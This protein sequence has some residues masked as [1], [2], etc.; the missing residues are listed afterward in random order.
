MSS[1]RELPIKH[2]V[3][4]IYDGPH[5][6]PAISSEGPIFLGIKNITD[7]GH[8]NFSEIRHV[9]ENEL[10]KW[11]RR[12]TPQAGDVVLTY[13]ATLHRYAIIPEGFRGC[14]GRRVALVRPDPVKVDS[15][16]LLFYF[17]SREWRS[18][19]E[20]FIIT[21]ATVNRI[22]LEKFPDFPVTLPALPEQQRIAAILS[23]YDDAME[24]NRRRMALLEKAAR[25]LYEEWFVR[26]RFPGHEH[27]PVKDGLPQGW[28]RVAFEEALVL[29]RGF[30]LPKELW[31]EGEFP[32]CG[33]TGIIGHHIAPKVKGPGVFT[34]RSGSLGIV[35]YIAEE[36]WPHNTALWVKEF[37]RVT[38]LFALFLMRG[39]NLKQYNGGASVPTLD[40]KA[41]HRVEI[42]L[43]PLRIIQVF[44]DSVRSIFSQL[45]NLALQ[46][47]KLRAA[48]DLLLPRLMSG[49]I[50]V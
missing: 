47:Q 43:P 3:L 42:L 27:S 41:V 12:V 15:R 31:E 20:R 17:L 38:P 50:E 25:L 26:L 45:E 49:E 35:N 1:R 46:N 32:I 44:D 18:V 33:S 11:T 4:G 22:P 30:D 19:V 37:K 13:E 36:Y 8:L 6:T 5:A 10:P 24:N 48:R 21:G 29:Q 16:F 9:S 14:L 28:E 2:Y 7:D 34:G 23:A 40:R 39:M